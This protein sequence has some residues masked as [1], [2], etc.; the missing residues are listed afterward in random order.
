M[1]TNWFEWYAGGAGSV[2]A[3]ATSSGEGDRHPLRAIRL[4]DSVRGS[5]VRTPGTSQGDS[6]GALSLRSTM[7]T[8]TLEAPSVGDRAFRREEAITAR[9]TDD[10]NLVLRIRAG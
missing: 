6:H 1:G 3:K 9:R 2:D 7:L 4:F 10:M 8:A 5:R